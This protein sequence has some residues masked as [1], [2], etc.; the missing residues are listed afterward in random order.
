MNIGRLARGLT[1]P[2]EVTSAGRPSKCGKGSTMF[3][4]RVFLAVALSVCAGHIL[5]ADDA[6][7]QQEFEPAGGRGRLVVVISGQT[8]P[9]NYAYL[10]KE[11]AAKGYFAVLV[12][13]NDMFG[14]GIPGEERLRG[15]IERNQQSPHAQPGKAAVV[16]FSLGGGATISYAPRMPE[17]VSV[18]V[19][20]YPATRQIQNP[21]AFVSRIQVPL[22]MMAGTQD[23]YHDCCSIDTARSL[24]A[25]A[26]AA[27]MD[28]KF[29]LVEYPTGHGWNI[30]FSKEYRSDI[31]ADSLRR[32]FD[33]IEAHP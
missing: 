5:A 17:L 9:K 20:S 12:D 6:P 22:L 1:A 31:S 16:G 26:K 18:A 8:G 23:S 27:G 21:K 32:T 15:V 3:L 25:E 24:A 33:F 10:A 19:V 7:A 29:Q 13:G 28:G 4:P 30:Q 14:K 11:I 2:G